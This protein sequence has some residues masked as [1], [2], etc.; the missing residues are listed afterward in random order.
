MW[1]LGLWADE[2]AKAQWDG[3]AR[4][5]LRL[6]ADSGLGGRR[7]LGWGRSLEPEFR[8]GAL[9][10]LIFD[11]M[12]GVQ[13]GSDAEPPAAAETAY[14]MLSLF[15]P[16]EADT[17]D[18]GRGS[19][20]LLTRGGAG[21][22]R[23]RRGEEAFAHGGR[24]QRDFRRGASGRGGA[25]CGAGGRR[26]SRVPGG[27]RFGPADALE[28]GAKVR[29][30]VTCL[31]PLL[32]GDGGK[33]SPIDY[34]VWKDQVNVLDQRRIFR[35]LAKGPRLEGYLS[36]LKRAE[37]LD[38][39]SWGGFAQNFAGRRIPFEHPSCAVHWERAPAESL[40]IPT[41]ATGPHGPYLPASAMRGALRTGMLFAGLEDNSLEKLA[42]MYQGERP[43]RRPGEALEERTLGLGGN[44][45][46]RAVGASDS[47]PVQTSAMKVYLLRV[48]SLRG[49][50]REGFDLGWKQSPSGTADGARPQDGYST[51]CRNGFAGHGLRRRLARERVSGA[52]RDCAGARLAAAGVA[53][54]GVRGGQS[55]CRGADRSP[56]ELRQG[57]RTGPGRQ[58]S[59]ANAGANQ[60]G[61]C[62]V[63]TPVFYPWGGGRG[64]SRMWPG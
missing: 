53:R 39:A 17:V 23:A 26:P 60:R 48:A 58:E 30:R 6:L 19:Y 62:R 14:W 20:S 50:R 56:R 38:F 47:D 45:R 57:R 44:S 61:A 21:V 3:S 5:A 37:K 27:L 46:L 43:P 7:S 34:M 54:R 10:D 64:C 52:A 42:A 51:V 31:T 36:Q 18:W 33:L 8:D 12:P 22:R 2:S 1:A 40:H 59:G 9:P 63:E 16:G 15:N 25:R 4:A 49:R 13:A 32:V 28:G 29:Y 11:S 24:R 35:L 55:V 41:F